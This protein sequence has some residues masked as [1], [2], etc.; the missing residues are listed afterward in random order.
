MEMMMRQRRIW[1]SSKYQ[2]HEMKMTESVST[3]IFNPPVLLVPGK[4]LRIAVALSCAC[5]IELCLR[6]WLV[7]IF[8]ALADRSTRDCAGIR[9]PV[10]EGLGTEIA[11]HKVIEVFWI[12]IGFW[13]FGRSRGQEAHAGGE[14]GRG[15]PATPGVVLGDPDSSSRAPVFTEGHS[16]FIQ[17]YRL[18]ES[19]IP[20]RVR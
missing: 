13:C 8:L 1:R 14:G 12:E 2:L 6:S 16:T 11:W 19:P 18:A 15:G 17:A 20:I 5:L 10:K 9:R 3:V 4:L 7:C